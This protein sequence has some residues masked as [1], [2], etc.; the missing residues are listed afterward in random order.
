MPYS[1]VFTYLFVCDEI[2]LQFPH[3]QLSCK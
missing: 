1:Y 2:D 3:K